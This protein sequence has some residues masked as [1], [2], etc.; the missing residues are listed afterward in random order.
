MGRP[1]SET[2]T[3]VSGWRGEPR[4]T[5]SGAW[6]PPRAGEI[7]SYG[8]VWQSDVKGK[9][10]LR[11]HSGMLGAGLFLETTGATNAV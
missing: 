11:P 7:P 8:D 6:T 2:G 9:T 1:T 10:M 5:A 3:P 4:T